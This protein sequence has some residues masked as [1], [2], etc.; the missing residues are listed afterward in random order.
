MKTHKENVPSIP[1]KAWKPFSAGPFSAQDQRPGRLAPCASPRACG[2]AGGEAQRRR[3]SFSSH[4]SDGGW[5]ACTISYDSHPAKNELYIVVLTLSYCS[6]P[7]RNLP[8]ETLLVVI[9][10]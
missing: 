3:D 4:G 7:Y 10:V 1:H 5:T 6:L 9:G 8:T 2:P